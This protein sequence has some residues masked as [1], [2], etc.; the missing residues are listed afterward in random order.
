MR[1]SNKCNCGIQWLVVSAFVVSALFGF[2]EPGFAGSIEPSFQIVCQ[3]P[4]HFGMF[5]V[6]VFKYVSSKHDHGVSC[7]VNV[8]IPAGIT[9]PE[10]ATL[11]ANAISATCGVTATTGGTNVVNVSDNGAGNYGVACWGLSDGTGE[12]GQAESDKKD[13]STS[14]QTKMKL[15]GSSSSGEVTF[16]QNDAV[17]T[18]TTDGK[19]LLEIYQ[20]LATAFGE[21]TADTSGFA[22]DPTGCNL[23]RSF[24]WEVTDPSLTIEITQ[25]EILRMPTAS[26]AT[27]AA[28]VVLLL[29]MGIVTI[30][31]RRHRRAEA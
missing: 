29:T 11:I 30:R 19:T 27:L 17:H 24:E 7:Q 4:D 18:V 25:E 26:G 21:G 23:P 15:T 1:A 10:K 12:Y 3:P 31:L 22:L 13:Q 14:Y 20:D 16:G 6:T 28:I 5:G 2:A 9:G 8:A